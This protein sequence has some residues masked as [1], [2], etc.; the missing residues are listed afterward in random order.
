MKILS[1]NQ[2]KEADKYTIENEPV[3][4]IDLMERAAKSCVDFIANYAKNH[5]TTITVF[6]GVGN[7]GG[8]GLAIARLLIEKGFVNIKTYVV[9]FSNN[10]SLDFTTNYKRL[11]KL[12]R[13]KHIVDGDF[14]PDIDEGIVVDAIFGVGL[15]KS[16]YGFTKELIQKI[17]KSNVEVISIDMPSGLFANDHNLDADS[18]IKA[19]F[20]LTFETPKLSLLLPYY[21]KFVGELIIKR[22]FLH[23]DFLKEVETNYFY[24]GEDY[25]SKFFKKRYKFSHKGTYGHSLMVGGSLGKMGAIQMATR[26]AVKSGSGLVTSLV[27]KSGY[28]IMQIAVPEAMVLVEE[29]ND[30]NELNSVIN[31][32]AIGIGP[33]MGTDNSSM[34][35]LRHFFEQNSTPLVLDADALNL[36][37]KHRDLLEILPEGAILTP[38]PKEFERLVGKWNNDFEKL[39]LASEFA[40]N[41]QVVLVLKGAHTAI[42][43]YQGNIYFNSTGNPALAT[44]G[45]GDVLTGIITSLLAQGMSNKDAAITGVY[46]HGL[47]ADIAMEDGIESQESFS[48][49][50]IIAYLGRAF[51]SLK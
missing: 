29:E 48:A 44:G 38:H 40:I 17:N 9:E 43:D 31:P 28:Q 36:I 34:E 35:I 45:S 25:I 39:K 1:P 37:S 24:V 22:I 18:I 41:Y 30:A 3:S 11:E 51:N 21:G 13:I 5:D 19:D 20:T 27:P 49:T 12:A 23:P 10:Y 15:N 47:A 50:D 14:L 32:S 4:S 16:P 6:C 8:D 7:N 26:A 2:L 42:F 46:I 33:G